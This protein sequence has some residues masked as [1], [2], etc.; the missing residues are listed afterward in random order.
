MSHVVCRQYWKYLLIQ[1]FVEELPGTLE[2]PGS[3]SGA[4]PLNALALY[5]VKTF[6]DT[7]QGAWIHG[8]YLFP[9][10]TMVNWSGAGELHMTYLARQPIPYGIMMKTLCYGDSKIMLAAEVSLSKEVTAKNEGRNINGA[11]CANTLRLT[12]YWAGSGRSVVADSWFGSCNTAG[13]LMD[14]HGLHSFLC[15]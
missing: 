7:W 11:S 6:A 8:M 14:V 4:G 2:D 13:H 12:K 9:D 3:G 15:V 10:E 5:L 1:G